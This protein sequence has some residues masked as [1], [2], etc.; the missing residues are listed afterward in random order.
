M[1]LVHYKWNL[2]V[3]I[4]VVTSSHVFNIALAS[5]FIIPGTTYI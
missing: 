3:Q 4:Q 1:E 5:Q 2:K